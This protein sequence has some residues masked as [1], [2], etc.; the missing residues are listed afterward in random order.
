MWLPTKLQVDSASRHAI[1]IAGTAIAIFGLQAKGISL[2]QV[3]EVI[4]ALG[5]TVNDIVLL[6]GALAPFYAILKA[7]NS[8]SSASQVAA[9]QA[10]ATGPASNGA[11]S[12]QKAL[13]QAVSA[14]A[15]DKSIPASEQAKNTLIAATVALPEVQT[16]ITDKKTADAI[17]NPSIIPAQAG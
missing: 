2:D 7:A 11:I 3:K 12:A 10:I 15:Q 14:V 6:L 8:A 1:S 9:V 17:S 5:S 16:I 4:S 13:I